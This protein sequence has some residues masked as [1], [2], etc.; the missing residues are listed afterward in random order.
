MD[1]MTDYKIPISLLLRERALSEAAAGRFVR[2]AQL[3]A[4]WN[5]KMNLTAI[6]EPEQVVIRH[7]ADSLT[8]LDACEIPAG[9]KVIDVGTGAGFPGVP[10]KIVREDI[11][12]TLL[13]SLAKRLTFLSEVTRELGLEARLVHDRAEEGGRRPELRGQF[14][15]ACARAV[16]ALP[17]LCEYC[18]PFV[19]KGGCF[20]AM[21]GPD[22]KAEIDSARRAI[23]LLGGELEQVQELSLPDGSGRTLVVVRKTAQTPAQYP[24]HGAKIAKSPL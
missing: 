4:Q 12:L 3:L 9:A 1:E 20:V 13:D 14:D 15:V 6:T 18:L 24:R 11:N 23:G 22:C 2:Y 5:E 17:V 21:K 10:L 7:F 16:A 8:L 19:K